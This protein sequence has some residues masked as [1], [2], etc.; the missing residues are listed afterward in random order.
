MITLRDI[1]RVEGEIKRLKI[2][3]EFLKEELN[4]KNS[5]TRIQGSR[6]SGRVRRASMDLSCALINMRR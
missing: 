2:S 6:A 1:K 5:W 3:M 4:D